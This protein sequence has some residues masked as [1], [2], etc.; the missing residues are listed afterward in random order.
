MIQKLQAVIKGYLYRKHIQNIFSIEIFN[1]KNTFQSIV[2]LLFR[3]KM[4]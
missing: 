4:I 2:R 3:N 1:K